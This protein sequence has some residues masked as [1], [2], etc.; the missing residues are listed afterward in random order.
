ME[1]SEKLFEV[2]YQIMIQQNRILLREIAVREKIPVHEM[3]QTF[4]KHPRKDFKKFMETYASS[5]SS[6]S[7]SSSG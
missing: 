6:S 7:S 4:L 1:L 5:S 3:Y 2:I